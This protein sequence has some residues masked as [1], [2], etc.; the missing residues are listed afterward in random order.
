MTTTNKR[1]RGRPA[2][3]TMPKPI[4]DTPENI[5]RAVVNTPPKDEWRYLTGDRTTR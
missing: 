2:R 1:K 3:R 5:M 4:L